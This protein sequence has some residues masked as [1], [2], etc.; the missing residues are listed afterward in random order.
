MMPQIANEQ[1]RALATGLLP[2][3]FKTF[4]NLVA[5]NQ[6]MSGVLYLPRALGFTANC[7]VNGEGDTINLSHISRCYTRI[8]CDELTAEMRASCVLEYANGTATFILG[9]M[10]LAM[11][12]TVLLFITLKMAG[13]N[14]V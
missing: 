11:S 4:H 13:H 8:K 12:D 9:S 3:E 14:R 1:L 5:V 2:D 6:D 10:S 7:A